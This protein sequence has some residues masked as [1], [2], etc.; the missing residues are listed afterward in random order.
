ME[1]PVQEMDSVAESALAAQF[2]AEQFLEP[3]LA[4]QPELSRPRAIA[5]A[6]VS[7]FEL[8]EVLPAVTVLLIAAEV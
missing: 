6:A 1:G 5:P 3:L 2:P 4:S 8:A 7:V